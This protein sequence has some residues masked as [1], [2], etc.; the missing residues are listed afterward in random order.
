M[1]RFLITMH[2]PNGSG[3][4][5]VHQITGDH[6]AETIQEFCDELNDK[7][8]IVV[9]Q[10]YFAT[11]HVTGEKLGWQDRGDLL[12]NTHHIGKAS[13]FFEHTTHVEDA[14]RFKKP[15]NDFRG[16]FRGRRNGYDPQY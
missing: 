1:A 14:P 6:P 3:N 9:R 13:V 2:M 12:L 11:H 16:D 4:S 15:Q 8:F 10:Q 5:P 7:A